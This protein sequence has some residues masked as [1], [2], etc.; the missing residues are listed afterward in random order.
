MSDRVRLGILGCGEITKLGHLPAAA[1][2]PGVHVIGLIDSD[3]NRARTLAR[4]FNLDCQIAADYKPLLPQVDAV[5]NALPN[6]LHAGVNLEALRAGVHVLCE[7]PLS[8]IAD[9]ARACCTL[10]DERGLLLAVG[11]NRRFVGS[12]SLLPMVLQEQS[13]GELLDYDWSSGNIFDWRSASGFYFSR[14]LAGGGALIDFGVHLLDSL[15]D[16]F[17]PVVQFDYHDDDWGSGIE[18][19]LIL[20]LHHEG[21]Y[22]PVKGSVRV[23][24]TYPLSN[25][26][27]LR[28]SKAQAEIPADD[29]DVVVIRRLVGSR[30]I[31]EALRLP[32][33]QNTSTF[34]KQLDNFAETIRGNQKLLS[35]G[36]QALRIIEL[37]EQ[38]YAS[39]Q[40]IPEPW[41]DVALEPGGAVR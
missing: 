25:R 26:M 24:R 34:Y 29:P 39:R 13:L 1:L 15:I 19:N 38:C 7:K 14:A 18:A 10:A 11:M 27:L 37:I 21:K 40:R 9:D 22:G 12:H 16:W 5:I 28:G 32:D 3:V 31:S 36:E 17:G 2:H 41:S 23:S 20:Q 35:T 8:T 6:S 30:E 33:F 4:Q